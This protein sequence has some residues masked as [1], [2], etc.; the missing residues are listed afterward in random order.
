MSNNTRTEE[1]KYLDVVTE[2]DK[3]AFQSKLN[4]LN[5]Q[6][7]PN[8][9]SLIQLMILSM[10]GAGVDQ[11]LQSIILRTCMHVYKSG[12]A[13][14]LILGMSCFAEMPVSKR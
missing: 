6:D 2:L 11:D 9:A 13:A 3:A 14:G 7:D 12:V 10:K 1:C 8:T 4:A 5:A